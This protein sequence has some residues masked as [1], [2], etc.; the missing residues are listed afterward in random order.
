MTKRQRLLLD[1]SREVR[2]RI[3]RGNVQP[4]DWRLA[5]VE[6]MD[7]RKDLGSAYDALYPT[8]PYRQVSRFFADLK[9]M[10][11]DD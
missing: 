3:R 11:F 5:A 8:E 9:R 2:V 4:T 1:L 6:I 7:A 10:I